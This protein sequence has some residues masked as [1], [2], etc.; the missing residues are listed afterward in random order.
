ML[1]RPS[2]TDIKNDN[3]LNMHLDKIL[4]PE[5]DYNPKENLVVNQ[6]K[7]SEDFLSKYNSTYSQ[8]VIEGKSIQ[9]SKVYQITVFNSRKGT[10]YI[11]ETDLVFYHDLT[12]I[13]TDPRAKC[14]TKDIDFFTFALKPH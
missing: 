4:D 14:D 10:L 3:W 1:K 7:L 9:F 8:Y 13:S 5:N 2:P 11:S 12:V 6:S